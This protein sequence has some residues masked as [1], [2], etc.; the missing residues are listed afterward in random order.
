MYKFYIFF[1]LAF[2][3][4]VNSVTAQINTPNC[5]SNTRSIYSRAY[6][7]LGNGNKIFVSEGNQ[8]FFK[9]GYLKEGVLVHGNYLE[10]GDGN[11]IYINADEK[12][13][14]FKSGFVKEA[15][16]SFNQYLKAG[17]SSSYY[18]SNSHKTRFYNSG[19]LK[20]FKMF[21]NQYIKT[22]NDESLYISSDLPITLH[23][24]GTLKTGKLIHSCFIKTAIGSEFIKGDTVVHFDKNGFLEICR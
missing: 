1:C 9:N 5:D 23:K 7:M 16:L 18:V 21:H 14:F 24:D 4:V 22:K 19:S 13:K 2:L 12:V 8:T 6:R 10:L 11:E 3:S 20:Q 17:S 15:N